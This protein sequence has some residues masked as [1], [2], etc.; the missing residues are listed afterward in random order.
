M[1]AKA[2]K[3]DTAWKLRAES[4][5]LGDE[6]VL[7]D[8]IFLTYERLSICRTPASVKTNSSFSYFMVI[9]RLARVVAFCVSLENRDFVGPSGWLKDHL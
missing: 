5:V 7:A 6:T 8:E 2:E 9:Q 4:S 3:I 1:I